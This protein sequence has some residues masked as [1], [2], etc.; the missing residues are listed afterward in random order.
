VISKHG[1]K[2]AGTLVNLPLHELLSY[3]RTFWRTI[4]KAVR[5]SHPEWKWTDID[6]PHLRSELLH[7]YTDH[8]PRLRGSKPFHSTCCRGG[9]TMP[10]RIV[11]L[12]YQWQL[13]AESK[14]MKHCVDSYVRKCRLEK[15]SIFS[16]RTDE[17]EHGSPAETSHLTIE[18]NR[19]TRKIIQV[20]GRWNQFFAPERIPLLRK[21]AHELDLVI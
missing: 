7:H 9:R 10:C 12:T 14:A 17:N 18:V 8:W 15:S 3:C 19:Q 1:V 2:R 6:C 4:L 16:L 11:E 13:V 20:R 21:W 5:V